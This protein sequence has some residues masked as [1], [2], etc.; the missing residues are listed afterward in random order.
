MQP[1]NNNDPTITVD[2]LM[3][4]F[5]L[6]EEILEPAILL[7]MFLLFFIINMETGYVCVFSVLYL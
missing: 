4:F 7:Y 1:Y 5:L 3:I 2:L 6:I